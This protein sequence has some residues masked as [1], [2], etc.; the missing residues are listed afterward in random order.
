MFR[1][2]LIPVWI[3]VIVLSGMFLMGQDSW[4]PVLLCVDFEDPALGSTYNVGMT[5][6]DSGADV[7][8][9]PFEWS[10]G[11]WTNNGYAEIVL[12]AGGWC[13]A[14]GSAQELLINNINMDFVFPALVE[15][16]LTVA[17]AEHGGNVNISINGDHKNVEDFISVDSTFV[18]GVYVT[19][20]GPGC[21]GSGQGTLTLDGTITQFSIGG[22]E[23]CIDD[24]CPI[25]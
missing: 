15:N 6:T 10:G 11:T 1:R 5:F 14:G 4:S 9:A 3:G 24:V 25:I 23:F 18:G 8:G 19:C 21:T 16:G 12:A 2:N 20:T 22:Q 13:D 7:T 17:F